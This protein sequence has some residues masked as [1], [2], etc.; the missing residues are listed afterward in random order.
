MALFRKSELVQ[1][2]ELLN[3]L[4]P[5]EDSAITRPNNG[6][7]S[8]SVDDGAVSIADI[9]NNMALASTLLPPFSAAVDPGGSDISFENLM[10]S[11]E[12]TEMAYSIDSL[13]AEWVSQTILGQCNGTGY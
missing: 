3:N 7:A 8:A 9:H 13:D 5:D 4:P 11:A 6:S 1:L 2:H 10:T 12:I